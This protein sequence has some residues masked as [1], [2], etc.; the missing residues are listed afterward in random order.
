MACLIQVQRADVQAQDAALHRCCRAVGHAV[1]HQGLQ[2]GR[3]A[4]AL[5]SCSGTALLQHPMSLST[6]ES[7]RQPPECLSQQARCSV[8]P[9]A[10][11]SSS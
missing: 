10:V 6:V 3:S 8:V 2:R 7:R 11:L 1:L 4:L 9:D 5:D